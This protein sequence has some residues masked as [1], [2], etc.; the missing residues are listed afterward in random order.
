ML[1][2]NLLKKTWSSHRLLFNIHAVFDD[3]TYGSFGPRA[4]YVDRL[5]WDYTVDLVG[6]FRGGSVCLN[7]FGRFT[8]WISASIMQPPS[9]M[10]AR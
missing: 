5:L 6:R 3:A 4:L 2:V 10:P 9:L 7:S 8:K 1:P